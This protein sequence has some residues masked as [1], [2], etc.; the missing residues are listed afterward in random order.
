MKKLI[1]KDI[2]LRKLFRKNELKRLYLKSLTS[3][4]NLTAD[5]RFQ[6]QL[7]LS[8]LPKNSAKN[9][10]KG[11]CVITGRPKSVFKQFKQSR[12]SLKQ[13][14]LNGSIPGLKKISW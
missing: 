5:V 3:N 2:K 13:N 11:R 7:T 9:R 6:A 8:N 14:A 4:Q 12:I 1:K 10:I